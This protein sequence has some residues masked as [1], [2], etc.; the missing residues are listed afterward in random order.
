VQLQSNAEEKNKQYYNTNSRG[1]AK[2][3]L[4]ISDDIRKNNSFKFVTE[5][6]NYILKLKVD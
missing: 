2:D 4:S 3:G 1:V 5:L 6:S